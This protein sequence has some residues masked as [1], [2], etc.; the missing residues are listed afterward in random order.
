MSHMT[1]LGVAL[2]VVGA[3]VIV[4]EAHVPTLGML[5]GPGVVALGVGTVLAI[6]GLGGGIALGLVT[7]LVLVA[8]SMAVLAVSLRK[9][10]ATRQRRVRAGPEH[11]IGH[12]G[13][14]KSWSDSNGQVLVD[15]ALWRARPSWPD[16]EDCGCRD[17]HEGDQVVVER[18]NGLTIAIRPAEEWELAQ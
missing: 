18:L 11:L 9:G 2:M 12:I 17:L 3:I 13:V 16:D 7:S 1:A 14:V 15:G 6:S 5:G 10:L 4:V 8:G